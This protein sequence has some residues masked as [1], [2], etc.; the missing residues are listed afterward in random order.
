[1]GTYLLRRLLLLIPTLIGM[2]M[3]IF[4]VMACSP[5]G[6]TASLMSNEGMLRPQE[7]EQLQEYLKARYGLDKPLPVQYLR[8]LNKVSPIGFKTRQV[9]DPVVIAA[10]DAARQLPPGPDGKPPEPAVRVGDMIFTQ[11][12]IKWPDLGDSVSRR[13]QVLDLIKEKLPVTL[14]LNLIVFP[15]VYAIAIL[16][17]IYAAKHRG[18]AFDV[19]SGTLFL[20]LWSVPTILTGVM[21]IGFLA[22]SQYIQLFP[23]N[24]LHD[25][26]AGEMTYL[27]RFTDA[28]FQR[29]YLL[30]MAW[31]MILPLFCLGYAQLAFLSKL[32][33][34]AVLENL[35]ADYARTAR[36]K[37]VSDSDVLFRH[38]FRNSLI[39]LIT[40]AAHILPAM[41]SGSVVVE[42]IFGID[43]MGLLMVNAVFGKDPEL[44]LS[45]SM[46]AGLLG[47][48]GYLLA[49]IGYAVADPRVSYDS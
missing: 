38:V 21:C 29:G 10:R 42:K 15:I 39:P 44:V 35:M 23:S 24:E 5:G 27:P 43:G 41:L 40:V 45:V 36:A 12:A 19:G 20:G 37:G 26:L 6:I 47:L 18:K 16:S 3:V 17:G 48:L 28:G 1:M 14:L 2:T 8:W 31:H 32:S 22:N 13:R 25:M 9:G 33:R 30:D 49:D 4:L 46:V 7:K 34:G 11:P